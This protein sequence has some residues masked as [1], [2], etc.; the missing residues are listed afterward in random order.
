M[1]GPLSHDSEI[2]RC[3]HQPCAEKFVPHTIDGDAGGEGV[4]WAR[5]PFRQSETIARGICGQWEKKVRR[6]G[7][8]SLGARRVH[9]TRQHMSIRDGGLFPG[10]QRQVTA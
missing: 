3:L 6:V 5:G 4:L 8:N 10:N 2:F 1:R 7:F 9:T